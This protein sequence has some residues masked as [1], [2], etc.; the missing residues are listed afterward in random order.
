MKTII[1][2]VAL[3]LASSFASAAAVGGKDFAPAPTADAAMTQR[4][5]AAAPAKKAK[6]AVRKAATARR[7]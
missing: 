4:K 6:K 1:P 5:V 7:A 2:A 3:L